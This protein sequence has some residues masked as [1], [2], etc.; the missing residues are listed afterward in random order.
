MNKVTQARQVGAIQVTEGLFK[1]TSSLIKGIP[2]SGKIGMLI[3]LGLLTGINISEYMFKAKPK[4][5][6]RAK[7]QETKNL[8]FLTRGY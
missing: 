2:K 1:N 8:D 3:S 4:S 7:N 6:Y 5:G